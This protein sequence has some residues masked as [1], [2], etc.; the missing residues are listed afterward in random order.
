MFEKMR[1]S[2]H[3]F[4][5]RKKP[6]KSKHTDW[7]GREYYVFHIP[8]EAE[9][10]EWRAMRIRTLEEYNNKKFPDPNDPRRL[11]LYE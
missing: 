2:I 4:F 11:K 9:T 7:K 10:P 3:K 6:W 5:R 1:H 8:P